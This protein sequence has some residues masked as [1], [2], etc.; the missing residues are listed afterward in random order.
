MEGQA[1]FGRRGAAPRSLAPAPAPAAPEPSLAYLELSAA[2]RSAFKGPDRAPRELGEEAPA[3]TRLAAGETQEDAE[4]KAF[5]GSNWRAYEPVW[6]KVRTSPGL[7]AGRS[8]PAA[9]F[10]PV[11]LLYRRQ[12]LFGLALLALQYA[13]LAYAIGGSAIF[14]LTVAGFFARYGKSIVVLAGLSKIREIA[15]LGLTPEGA[16]ERMAASGGVD[17][18]AATLGLIALGA[19]ALWS[20][21]QGA[22][23]MAP[24][25]NELTALSNLFRR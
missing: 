8:L 6:L 1:V 16:R 5:I 18:L 17:P 23:S 3:E 7:K 15:K 11:W 2:A 19:L 20:F 13:S 25:P 24:T 10:G 22:F 12:Y 9:L 14:D 21:D 4:M